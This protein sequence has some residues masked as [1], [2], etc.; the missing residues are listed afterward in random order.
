MVRQGNSSRMAE[1]MSPTQTRTPNPSAPVYYS[2]LSKVIVLAMKKED[3]GSISDSC[4]NPK[5]ELKEE[6]GSHFD[7]V[8]S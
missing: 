2:L 8:N 5:Y 4:S 6:S 3:D 1:M 7:N